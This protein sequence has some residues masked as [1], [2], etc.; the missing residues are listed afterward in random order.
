MIGVEAPVGL[1]DVGEVLRDEIACRAVVHERGQLLACAVW[2][3]PQASDGGAA[4]ERYEDEAELVGAGVGDERPVADGPGEMQSRFDVGSDVRAGVL[5]RGSHPQPHGGHHRGAGLAALDEL[6]A[7][8]TTPLVAID[9]DRFVHDDREVSLLTQPC[10]ALRGSPVSKVDSGEVRPAVIAIAKRQGSKATAPRTPSTTTT[11][12][13]NQGQT[14]ATTRPALAAASAE[15]NRAPAAACVAPHP[16]SPCRLLLVLPCDS[17]L[18]AGT[19]RRIAPCREGG[20]TLAGSLSH[21]KRCTQLH[22][23]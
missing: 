23:Q 20:P 14:A 21:R 7:L 12:H 16:C 1:W 6:D 4:R 13:D 5:L 17:D 22:P 3:H 2:R 15:I 18:H 8:D 11:Q 9:A 19:S 10:Q